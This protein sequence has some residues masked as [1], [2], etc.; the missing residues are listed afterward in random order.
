MHCIGTLHLQ[1]PNIAETSSLPRR[2]ANS[3]EQSFDAKK[4]FVGQALCQCA[5]KRTLAATKI[6]VQWRFASKDLF[7]IELL[8]KRI[9]RPRDHSRTDVPAVS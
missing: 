6:D 5:K 4:V 7:Q 8:C 1:Q 3:T 2:A 9:S